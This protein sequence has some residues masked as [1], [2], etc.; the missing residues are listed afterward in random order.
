LCL[1]L[2]VS[3]SGYYVWA[4]RKAGKRAS[5]NAELLLKIRRIFNESEGRYGSPKVYRALRRQGVRVGENRVARLMRE[6]G[7]K[8][9]SYRIYRRLVTRRAVL[10]A[11]PN[12][13]LTLDKPVAV[14]QQWSSDVTYIKMGRKNVFL[15]VVLDLYSRRII[16]WKLEA[17]LNSDLSRGA[18]RQAMVDR[19]PLPGLLLHTDRGTEFR[20]LKMRDMLKRH[21]V[22]HS[23]SRPGYCTD[24]AEVESFFKSLKGELL[25]ATSYITL[26]QLRHHI[27]HYI[28]RF[29]NTQRLHSSLGYRTPLEFEGAN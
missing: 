1:H 12:H 4:N 28:E 9:R 18:L 8:A 7:M 3:R 26:R 13:R 16:G 23:M 20:A 21:Q 11:W 19:S 24:N 14:N 17:N 6:W 15:A 22:R 10:R 27:K 2:N 5:E 29:Y 25:H